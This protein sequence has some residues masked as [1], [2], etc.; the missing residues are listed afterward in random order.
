M[1]VNGTLNAT[2]AADDRYFKRTSTCLCCVCELASIYL[3][4]VCQETSPLCLLTNFSDLSFLF[5]GFFPV[6]HFVCLLIDIRICFCCFRQMFFSHIGV[7]VNG[8]EW[9][10]GNDVREA[11]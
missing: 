9:V 8:M 1:A 3:V 11:R 6:M 5:I 4:F 2:Q 10:A 7:F